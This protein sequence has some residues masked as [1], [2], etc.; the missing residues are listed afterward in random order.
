MVSVQE[1]SELLACLYAAPLQPAK[2]QQFF[3]H[4]SRL[5]KLSIGTLSAIDGENHPVVLAG[6]GFAFN[7][8]AVRQYNEY[9]SALDPF[10]TPFFLFREPAILNGEQLFSRDELVKTEFYGGLLSRNQMEFLTVMSISHSSAGKSF[11][12]LWRRAGDGA[13]DQDS[14]VLLSMLLP[15]AQTALKLRSEVRKAGLHH[16]LNDLVF[17]SVGF[18]AFVVGSD[19]TVLHLNKLAERLVASCESLSIR[20]DVLIAKEAAD[21]RRLANLIAR[22][23]GEHV[24]GGTM[25]ICAGVDPK[26]LNLSVLPIPESCCV[27]FGKK[28]VL[29]LA[30][31]PGLHRV[32]RESI[33]C[34]LYGLTPTEARLAALIVKGDELKTAAEAMRITRETARFHLKRVLAKTCTHSQAELIRLILLLPPTMPDSLRHTG[35]D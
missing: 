28:L 6:G 27:L 15:H 23:A 34:E 22:A 31:V 24:N 21:N 17:E 12:T 33:L 25:S 16:E 29:V 9:Y 14:L 4:L 26:A 35:E 2:W 30:S 18:A 8:D 32:S 11:M 13:M 10:A 7:D 5:T 3:D 1:Y 19:G 20:R